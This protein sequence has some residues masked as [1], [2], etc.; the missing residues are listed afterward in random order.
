M[1]TQKKKNTFYKLYQLSNKDIA[2]RVLFTKHRK[3]PFS[4]FPK[5]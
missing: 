4:K 5:F 3:K 1:I 2:T